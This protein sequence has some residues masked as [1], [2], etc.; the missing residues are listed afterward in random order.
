MQHRGGGFSRDEIVE[1]FR[2]IDW[3]LVLP[4]ALEQAFWQ[5]LL[6]FE[7]EKHMPYVTSVEQRGFEQ[8]QL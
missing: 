4:V 3:L 5:E 6:Q 2:F 7:E 1:L 8:G